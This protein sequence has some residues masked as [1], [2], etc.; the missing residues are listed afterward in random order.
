[1]KTSFLSLPIACILSAPLCS[2]A[3]VSSSS[4]APPPVFKTG[5]TNILVDVVVTDDH[6]APVDDL[7]QESF[8][9]LENG[10]PQQVVAFEP[11]LP[12][13]SPAHPAATPLPPGAYTNVPPAPDQS[14]LDVLLIDSLNTPVENQVRSHIMLLQYLKTLP[15]GKPV[16]VFLLDTQLH[17]LEDFTTDHTGLL[18]TV[19]FFTRNPQKSPL[20]KSKQDAAQELKDQDH[21]IELALMLPPEKQ[22]M[23][24]QELHT[25]QQFQAEQGSFNVDMRV[26]YTLAAFDRLSRYLSGVPGRK[27]VMWLSGSFPISILPDPDLKNPQQAARDFSSAVQHTSRLLANARIALYPMDARGLSPQSTSNPAM[28]GGSLARTPDRVEKAESGEF[29]T[30][31]QEHLSLEQFARATGGQAIYGTND[32]KAALEEVDRNGSHYYSLAYVPANTSQDSKL[33]RIDVRVSP[34]KYHLAYR[35]S[36]MPTE[37]I[38]SKHVGNDFT[39][40]LAHE[41]PPSTQILFHLTP[42]V[43]AA[44]PD[45]GAPIL[46]GN[47]NAQRPVTRFSMEW[48]VAVDPLALTPAADGVLHGTAT[49]LTIAYDR[50][51][52]PLNSVSNTLSIKVPSG[53]YDAF[54]KTGIHYHQNLDV[55]AQTAW[56]RT[57]ILDP[58][59]GLM[60]TLEIP[61]SVKPVRR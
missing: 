35:H 57:G 37:T 49:L 15:A 25:L 5:T 46:G 30:N 60:G 48:S 14:A 41:A 28:D 42:T 26:E 20:L 6:G 53:D 61:F 7:Q 23:A 47:P 52:K 19:E 36:Y 12:S 34:G 31:V 58:V 10:K 59:S 55:P 45:A 29:T 22:G 17:Q 33:R 4:A 8:T 1:M 32:L 21:L 2:F 16:A 56:L 40:L 54:L 11:H 18:K 51:G 13:H 24:F 3:Q 38:D 39:T 43:A 27:N 9:V 50:D 44:Q